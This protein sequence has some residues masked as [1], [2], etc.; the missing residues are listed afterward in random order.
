MRKD[1]PVLI[2]ITG[3]IFAFIA[4]EVAPFVLSVLVR[5]AFRRLKRKILEKEDERKKAAEEKTP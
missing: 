2:G 3:K 5:D 4:K 1:N